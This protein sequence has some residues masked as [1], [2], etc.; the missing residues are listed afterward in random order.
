MAASMVLKTNPDA[1]E[2]PKVVKVRSRGVSAM[3]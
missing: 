1:M 3:W 2:R